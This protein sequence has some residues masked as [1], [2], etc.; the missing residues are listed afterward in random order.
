MSKRTFIMH[1]FIIG[2]SIIENESPK[3]VEFSVEFDMP[4]KDDPTFYALVLCTG[5]SVV[6]RHLP[7]DTISVKG[8][9]EKNF[10]WFKK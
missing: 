4:I 2:A 7:Y 8:V 6:N 1:Y 3:T 5:I 9:Q 10:G